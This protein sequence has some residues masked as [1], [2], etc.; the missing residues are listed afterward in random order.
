MYDSGHSSGGGAVAVQW[1]AVKDVVVHITYVDKPSGTADERTAREREFRDG[2]QTAFVDDARTVRNTFA[3]IQHLRDGGV[4]FEALELLVRAQV[5][6]AIV[7]SDDKAEQQ[8]VRVLMVH[9]RTTVRVRVQ[10]PAN[11]VR[12]R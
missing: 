4:G 12:H 2:L 11:G 8:Q 7:Q 1:R 6:V 5:R 10:W 3:A 9:E